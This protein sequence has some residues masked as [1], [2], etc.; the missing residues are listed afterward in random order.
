MKEDKCLKCIKFKIWGTSRAHYIDQYKMKT[1][2]AIEKGEQTSDE[3]N[4]NCLH[5]FKNNVLTPQ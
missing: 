1:A 3:E 5:H 2:N 4:L